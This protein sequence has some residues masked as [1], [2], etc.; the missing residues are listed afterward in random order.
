M[1]ER[2]EC[3]PAFVL[4]T[5]Y[6]RNTSLLVDLFTES[7]GRVSVLARSA[8]GPK[9]RFRGL[10]QP[11][12]PLLIGYGGKS[13]LKYLN[14]LELS[15]AP[16]SVNGQAL[17]CGFYLNEL[18]VRLLKPEDAYTDLYHHYSATLSLL[19]ARADLEV[20]LRCFEKKLLSEL[21][22]GIELPDEI[23]AALSYHFIA[24][25]GFA[26]LPAGRASGSSFS[27]EHLLA[28]AQDEY[29]DAMVLASAKRLMRQALAPHLGHRPLAS[30]DVFHAF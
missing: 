17:Y 15:A 7:Q 11:F 19:S 13:S 12:M 27:G 8:R 9:S 2:V 5:R 10:L 24:G 22:F 23:E 6:Y 1:N 26:P 29:S 25:Q 28:I 20:V 16:F 30:R 4:H 14:Q 3:E 21:G 18:L